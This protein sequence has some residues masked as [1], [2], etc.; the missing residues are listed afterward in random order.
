MKRFV[1]FSLAVASAIL[2]VSCNVQE[3]E[4]PVVPETPAAEENVIVFTANFEATKAQI[5]TDGKFT[6][7]AGDVIRITDNIGYWE[8]ITLT[9]E[10]ISDDGASATFK[11]TKLSSEA[12]DFYA[13][14]PFDNNTYLNDDKNYVFDNTS[15]SKSKVLSNVSACTKDETSFCFHSASCLIRFDTDIEFAVAELEGPSWD[16]NVFYQIKYTVSPSTGEVVSIA[17]DGYH[18]IKYDRTDG[19]DGPYYFEFAP[20]LTWEKGF[21]ITLSDADGKTL[22]SFTYDKSLTTVRGK[23]YNIKNFDERLDGGDDQTGYVKVT[24]DLSDWS[25]EYLLVYESSETKGL[26]WTGVDAAECYAEAVIENGV[27][28]SKP[29]GAVTVT[30]ASMNGG[31]S[32]KVNEGV[33]E[34]EY[35]YGKSGSNSIQFGSE[36]VANEITITGGLVTILSNSTSFRYNSTSGQDRFRY[37]KTTTT[38]STYICPALYKLAGEPAPAKTLTSIAVSGTP[39]KTEYYAGD[40]FDPAGL[41]VTGTYDDGS[42][43][44]IS[45]GITWTIDPETLA[46]TTTSVSVTATVGELTSPACNVDVTVN[47]IP[48]KTIEEFIESE[49]GKCYLTGVVSNII[50]A[51]YGN[52]DLTDESG[53]IF[54]YGC[55]TSDGKSQKFN[56]L[57]VSAGDKITVLAEEYKYYNE[58]THEAINV[59][60]VEKIKAKSVLTITAPTNGTL[61]VKNGDSTVA[62]GS[63]IE[64][65]TELT[66]VAT[67]AENYKLASITVKDADNAVVTVTNNKFTMPASA[68][69]VSATFEKTEGGASYTLNSADITA[70]HSAAWAY[71]SGSKTITAADGSKWIAYNTY[72]NKNQ[73]TIQMNKGKTSYVLTP[74]VPSGKS[75]SHLVVTCSSGSDGKT[76]T[77]V[78]RTFDITDAST[79]DAIATDIAGDELTAGIDVSGSHT[80]LK[81]APNETNGGAC[82]IVNITIQYN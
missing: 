64:E 58:T 32:I 79:G 41:V 25:G 48:E 80:Q 3:P 24:S 26:C 73:V 60:F 34:G 17:D 23:V 51:T 49:G 77:G 12:T 19:E 72:A 8:V 52:F 82:Y 1:K 68:V 56:T 53:T 2:A 71:T 65:G 66:I 78:I 45:S 76:T 13:V 40:K 59:I 75:I 37:F 20:G 63:E 46:E 54:I 9:D 44:T 36:A 43:A 61:I 30:I 81:I 5:G 18:S 11:T 29:D 42:Q 62:T 38:G 28:S 57:G 74:V 22:G 50:S 10:D 6:W 55:L 27:I 35:I 70:A 21:V 14:Y 67:P 4:A 39:D 16:D 31:Y 15:L 33:N 7:E 47:A 69:T